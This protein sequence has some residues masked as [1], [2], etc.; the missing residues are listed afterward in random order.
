MFSAGD[1]FFRSNILQLT[2]FMLTACTV[3]AFVHYELLWDFV[4]YHYYN[5]YAFLN[6]RL[7]YDI[8][9]AGSVNTFFNPLMDI[10]AYLLIQ[11][12]NDHP[13]VF[14]F[15]MGVPY[16]LLLFVVFK[17]IC[18][19]FD[20]AAFPG[21]CAAAAAL[22][23]SA[24][25]FATL[26]QVST[27]TNEVPLSVLAV[28]SFYL[29]LKDIAFTR[30]F[31]PKT[32]IIA[33]FLLGAAFGLKLNFVLYCASTGLTLILFYR[34]LPKPKTLIALF[35]LAGLAGF[36][37]FNGFWMWTMWKNYGNPVFP[38]ANAVFKSPYFDPV[39]YSDQ[40]YLKDRSFSE[41]V[42]YPILLS[43]KFMFKKDYGTPLALADFRYAA[44]FLLA[45]GYLFLLARK[46]AGGRAGLFLFVWLSLSYILWLLSFS[47]LRYLIPVETLLSIPIVKAFRMLPKPKSI[48]GEGAYY[49]LAVFG[50]FIFLTTMVFSQNYGQRKTDQGVVSFER[51]VLPDD[52][53]A[54]VY[55]AP[56]AAVIP[57]LAEETKNIRFLGNAARTMRTINGTDFILRGRFTDEKAEIIRNHKGLTVSFVSI[58]FA[59][60]QEIMDTSPEPHICHQ[61]KNSFWSL[62]F[63]C[64]PER[65]KSQIL[66]DSYPSET[67]L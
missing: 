24:T 22:L 1:R 33:G 60:L 64:V 3:S 25:G 45:F 62:L 30:A 18:L 41:T 5:P 34:E 7:N 65:L 17:V 46:K 21:R 59:Q 37:T 8:T 23:I 43:F 57:R 15:F 44:G 9:P 35:S 20:T 56:A 28:T 53:L 40:L 39:N 4:N 67:K 55:G 13:L 27:T 51:I 63:I 12:L 48:P 61:L 42:F 19:F 38:F 36:L 6:G 14:S 66:P 47:I 50:L 58:S 54:L 32:Y 49:A 16:G 11:V 10:P 31:R 26:A 52:T 29:L 2:V